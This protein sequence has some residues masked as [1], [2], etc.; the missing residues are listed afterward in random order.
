MGAGGAFWSVVIGSDI[1]PSEY[2]DVKRFQVKQIPDR[3]CQNQS[4]AL[5]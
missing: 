5:K 4:F 2:L 3:S 1:V